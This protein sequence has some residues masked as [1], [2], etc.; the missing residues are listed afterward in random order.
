LARNVSGFQATFFWMLSAWSASFLE[1][2]TRTSWATNLQD[3]DVRQF[4]LSGKAE[5]ALTEIRESARPGKLP[6]T[7]F[8]RNFGNKACAG[9]LVGPQLIFG[10]LLDMID[11]DH[12]DGSFLSAQL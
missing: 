4:W 1:D 3:C 5:I 6:K 10:R 2:M 11:D 7:P 9:S 12:I 8:S